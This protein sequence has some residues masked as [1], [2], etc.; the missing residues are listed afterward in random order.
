MRQYLKLMFV[1]CFNLSIKSGNTQFI[2][3]TAWT[4]NDLKRKCFIL[5]K[6]ECLSK[7]EPKCLCMHVSLV[8]HF[9]LTNDKRNNNTIT[10]KKEKKLH[11]FILKQTPNS[12]FCVFIAIAWSFLLS[13]NLI[14]YIHYSRNYYQCLWQEAI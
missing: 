2:R 4:I 9:T 6:V 14:D 8:Q 11:N 7:N 5:A 12:Y 1:F 10:M 13:A 3:T